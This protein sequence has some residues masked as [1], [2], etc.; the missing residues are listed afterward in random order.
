MYVLNIVLTEEPLRE[1]MEPELG[2]GLALLLDDLLDGLEGLMV[3]V[4]ELLVMG[5]VEVLLGHQVHVVESKILGLD[6][7]KLEFI[8]LPRNNVS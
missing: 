3:A 2:Q 5:I 8:C 4:Q 7:E 6:I 1:V